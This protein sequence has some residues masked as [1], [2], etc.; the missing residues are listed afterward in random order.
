MANK[1]R[2]AEKETHWREVVQRQAA[3]GMSVRAFCRQQ[4]LVESAFYAWRRTIAERD[5]QV[6]I[7]KS[8]PTTP[9]IPRPASSEF[10]QAVVTDL[11]AREASIALELA[12]GRVL[13]LP[14]STS[15][16]RLAQLNTALEAGGLR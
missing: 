15:V 5:G 9:C 11:P 3:S 1:Q 8:K 10:V 4:Q 14:A 6:P 12:G 2:D 7:G 16:E 13:R